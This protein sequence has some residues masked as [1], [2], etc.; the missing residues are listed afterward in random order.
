M[1]VASQSADRRTRADEALQAC[2]WRGP[3]DVPDVLDRITNREIVMAVDAEKLKQIYDA[4]SELNDN[5]FALHM[6]RSVEDV[7]W[8]FDNYDLDPDK[9]F[10]AFEPV[11]QF[12]E[13]YAALEEEEDDRAYEEW[14]QK[15]SKEAEA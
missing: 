15:Q 7:A 1:A 6:I 8:V 14:K 12:L 3:C 5:S 2:S 9:V 4:V 11:L 10:A 13:C